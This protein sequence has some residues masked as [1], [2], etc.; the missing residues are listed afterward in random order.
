MINLSHFILI[1][2]I[3][4]SSIIFTQLVLNKHFNDHYSPTEGH[5]YTISS[6]VIKVVPSR[7]CSVVLL[8]SHGFES[9]EI[10]PGKHLATD[11]HDLTIYSAVYTVVPSIA[12]SVVLL[13]SH[14][15]ESV[16]IYP[17]KHLAT[18][19]HE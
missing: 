12:C 2:K 15:F 19:G 7:A 18:E 11:G 3:L 1:Y 14:G 10:Y 6:A 16:E 13:W 4:Y 9:V 8:W 17:G 5:E